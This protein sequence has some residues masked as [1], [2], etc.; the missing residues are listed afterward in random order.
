[1]VSSERLRIE[2]DHPIT[3]DHL[4][5]VQLS[6]ILGPAAP[7]DPRYITKIGLSFDNGKQVHRRLSH[8]SRTRAGEDVRFPRRTFSTLELEIEGVHRNR[9]T[10]ATQM[11]AIGINEL[12]LIDDAPGSKPVRIR[13]AQRLPTDLLDSMGKKSAEHPLAFVLSGEPGMDGAAMSRVFSLPTER[14][15]NL[16]GIATLGFETS[17]QVQARTIGVPDANAGGVTVSSKHGSR[18]PR[19]SPRLALDGDPETAWIGR[20]RKTQPSVTV[21]VPEPITLDHLDLQLVADGRHSVPT[22]LTITSSD[23]TT[24]SSRCRSSPRPRSREESLPRRCSSRRCAGTHSSSRCT[25]RWSSPARVLPARSASRSSEFPESVPPHRRC[26][27]PAGARAILSRSTARRSRCGSRGPRP[28]HW[29]SDRSRSARAIRVRRS[30]S[31]PAGMQ[32]RTRK[33]PHNPT[34]FDIGRIVLASGANGEPTTAGE[35]ASEAVSSSVAKR[36]NVRVAKEDATSMTVQVDATSEPFWLVLGQSYNNGWVAKA[37]GKTLEDPQLVDGYAN[38]WQVRPAGHG[39]MTITLEWVPQRSFKIALVISF[40]ATLLCLGI[41]IVA[42]ARRR[43]ARR[44]TDEDPATPIATAGAASRMNADDVLATGAAAP[45]Q[46][47]ASLLTRPLPRRWGLT[48]A[49]VLGAGVAAALL[50]RPWTGL[51]IAGLV[52]LAILSPK[53]RLVIRFVPPLIVVGVALYMAV[54]QRIH[55]YPASFDWPIHFEAASVPIWIRGG[56]VGCGCRD[57]DG[58]AFRGRTRARYVVSG[59]YPG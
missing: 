45:P 16:E 26:S 59:D 37:D 30:T 20:I 17:D 4:N 3:T 43:R 28:M 32:I 38:G 5:L 1:M 34:G 7:R 39:P 40:L 14:S 22:E 24:R 44:A 25:L 53:W 48:T 41:V 54:G 57:R 15:F 36:P 33:S 35:L 21:R 51:L 56:V 49:T 47:R 55:R 52:L 13:E 6:S 27:S 2:L 18:A 9:R 50:I 19:A 12:R 58:L 23:G 10:V 46:L 42:V 31:R 11:N 8:P 29:T